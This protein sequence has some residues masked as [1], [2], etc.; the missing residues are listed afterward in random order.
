M[1]T[2]K[3][4]RKE[5]RQLKANHSVAERQA[6][7]KDICQCLMC[8]E[9]WRKTRVVLLYHALS[10]EVDTSLL[11]CSALESG[12]TVLLPVVVGDD[13]ELRCYTGTE[14]LKEGAFG[15]MEP[16]GAPFPLSR[17]AKVDLVVVPGMAFDGAGHRLGRGK[18]YY[19]RLLPRLSNARK[20]GLCF[21]FQR[22][23]NVPSESHDVVMDDVVSSS[24]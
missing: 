4:L 19:D 3:E 2:K 21:S 5:I 13:L 16:V 12:K 1:M 23:E 7:A 24:F 10:D 17:Y 11:L 6:M 14:S 8:S 22:L 18:G 15:I 20:V 9:V